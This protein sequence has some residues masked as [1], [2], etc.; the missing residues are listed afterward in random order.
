MQQSEFVRHWWP[1]TDSLDLVDGPVESVAT[2]VLTE[3]ARFVNGESLVSEWVQFDSMDQI[4]RSMV[5][6]TNVPTV[7]YVLPTRSCWTVL[8]NNSY[9]CAGYDSL[10]WCLTKNHQMRTIHWRSSDEDAVFQAGTSFTVRQPTGGEPINRSVYCCKN[11]R[12]WKFEAYGEPLIEE[13]TIDYTA[14]RIKDRLNEEKMANLLSRLKATPWQDDFYHIGKAFR[15][16]RTTFPSTI[17][18]KKFEDFSRI[19]D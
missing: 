11:D 6:Y 14:R 13:S 17:T 16:Q 12:R 18:T 19:R 4:L 3:V 5:E 9:L 1:A 15:I 7:Y 8:W 10:C 2:A